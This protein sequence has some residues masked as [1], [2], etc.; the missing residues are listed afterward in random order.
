MSKRHTGVNLDNNG[1][2]FQK[3]WG[4]RGSVC[5]LLMTYHKVELHFKLLNGTASNFPLTDQSFTYATCYYFYSVLITGQIK[6]M[7]NSGK[8][9]TSSMTGLT[10]RT[11]Y[12][13]W[14]LHRDNSWHGEWQ[15]YNQPLQGF[16]FTQ[17]SLDATWREQWTNILSRNT[18]HE[19]HLFQIHNFHVSLVS[20]AL[21]H[22]SDNKLCPSTPDATS[23]V[24]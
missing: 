18:F 5:T 4:I 17:L 14:H 3:H 2:C 9:L 19:P 12:Y 24:F 7:Q 10:H 22:S 21:N 16:A 13:F 1:Y 15:K 11:Q 6:P 20:H 8:S 23:C